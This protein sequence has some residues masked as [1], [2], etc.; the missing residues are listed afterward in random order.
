MTIVSI[1]CLAICKITLK[2][3]TINTAT[4]LLNPH[5]NY[6][7]LAKEFKQKKCV[8][9]KNLL[10]EDVADELYTYFASKM[11]ERMWYTSFNIPSMSDEVGFLQH[12]PE[13]QS[14]IEKLFAAANSDF[15]RGN[16][17]YIFDRTIEHDESCPC[18]VCKHLAF[19]RDSE[20]AL[21][22]K[23][24]TGLNITEYG[25]VFASRYTPGQFLS[26]HND[27]VKGTLSF[28]FGLSKNWRPEY[29]GNLFFLEDDKTTIK[30][31]VLSSFN[32]MTLTLMNSNEIHGVPHFVSHVT[33]GV[34]Q[35]RLSI[36]G[37]INCI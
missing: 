4:R 3:N 31:V 2:H 14:K 11:P 30:K 8:V 17:S 20:I 27:R 15:I 24:I 12:I 35:Q 1:I 5:L 26:T 9:I 32:T 36:T 19:I 33:D 37:W 34:V 18:S 25:E 22:V 23:L 10:R 16:F 29:G 13:N 6:N 21:L 28:V 7:Q